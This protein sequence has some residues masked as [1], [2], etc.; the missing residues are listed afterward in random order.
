MLSRL[1]LCRPLDEEEAAAFVN[2]PGPDGA[3]YPF[4]AQRGKGGA[5]TEKAN[6]A[7]AK[8]P[9]SAGGDKEKAR[10]EKGKHPHHA[11]SLEKYS[12]KRIPKT[13]KRLLRKG[14]PVISA[15]RA[16]QWRKLWLDLN[17]LS[18]ASSTWKK[19]GSALS[20]F[21]KFCDR[22]SWP[23]ELPLS[24]EAANSFVL[25]GAGEGRLGSGTIKAYA[26]AL[27]SLGRLFQ[28]GGEGEGS[29]SKMLLRGIE[30]AASRTNA[31]GRSVAP[32]TFRVLGAVKK[33]LKNLKWKKPSKLVLWACCCAG[34]FGSFRAGELLAKS[35]TGF[36]KNS[37]LLWSDVKFSSTRAGKANAKIRIRAP[38]TR[39]P[40]GIV[41]DLFSF[42]AKSFCPIRA[43]KQLRTAQ[44]RAGI[45]RPDKPVFRFGSGKNLTVRNL[46]RTLKKVLRKTEMGK[47]NI[48]ASSLRSGVPTDME[49]RPDLFGDSQIKNWGRWRSD[50]YRRYM[51]CAG[52][53][54]EILFQ[55]LS[56]LLMSME[57]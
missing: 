56:N 31:R 14:V 39:N 20:A 27:H 29:V 50:A 24:S 40:G 6:P 3:T 41:V 5:A 15:M 10:K 22:F 42:E 23:F 8:Q 7:S 48:T 1:P 54:K 26:G 43:L 13:L 37:D 28:K 9:S 49:S 35:E 12:R 17:S 11:E 21:E 34:Y 51:K 53:Q 25:W 16:G 44:R 18:L 32:F 55:S 47:L 36:D 52:V 46:S 33:R 57:K 2:K 4:A 30:N 38:K 19:Y 45:W